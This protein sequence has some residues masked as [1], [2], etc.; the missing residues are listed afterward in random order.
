MVIKITKIAT[1]LPKELEPKIAATSAAKTSFLKLK[2]PKSHEIALH[3]ASYLWPAPLFEG[4]LTNGP[5]AGNTS[6]FVS[7]F[8]KQKEFIDF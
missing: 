3:R 6:L 5:L 7:Y 1:K 4:Y 2:Q 8:K